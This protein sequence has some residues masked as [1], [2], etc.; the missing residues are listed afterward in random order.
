MTDVLPQM[1]AVLTAGQREAADIGAD[2]ME[3]SAQN[4]DV[5]IGPPVNRSAF[6]GIASDGRGLPGLLTD[7]FVGFL[8]ALAHGVQTAPAMSMTSWAYD[9]IGVTQLHDAAREAEHV[10]LVAN[11]EIT[12]YTR[13]V[14][15]G[16]CGR[17]VILAGRFY[18]WNDGFDRHPKC[19]CGHRATSRSNPKVQDP[20]ELFSEMSPEQQDRAFTKAGAQAIRDGSDPARVVNARNGMSTVQKPSGR[21]VAAR[22]DVLGRQVFTTRTLTSGRNAPPRLMPASIYELATD[23]ADAIRLLRLHGFIT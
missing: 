12:G 18:R 13:F 15:P 23:R 20:R 19:R 22:T 6:A 9:R 5:P 7:P 17:C 10:G 21:L 2:Y 14:E 16:A 3:Q 1:I 8:A 4:L 11:R